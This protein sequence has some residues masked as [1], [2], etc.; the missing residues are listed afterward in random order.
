M[1]E[2]FISG[3][4]GDE[5]IETIE[6]IKTMQDEQLLDTYRALQ[7][8]IENSIRSRNHIEETGESIYVGGPGNYELT[9]EMA[10]ENIERG[11]ATLDSV[12]TEMERRGLQ[13]PTMAEREATDQ[14]ENQQEDREES[15]GQGEGM[16]VTVTYTLEDWRTQEKK[17]V[18]MEFSGRDM[19]EIAERVVDHLFQLEMGDDSLVATDTKVITP[20]GEKTFDEFFAK[21]EGLNH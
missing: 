10:Q 18:S 3:D 8:M 15:Q 1:F 7:N 19:R 21:E 9:A 16:T 11:F 4:R 17:P 20:E 14:Q 12:R 13:A 6:M 5:K 2:H